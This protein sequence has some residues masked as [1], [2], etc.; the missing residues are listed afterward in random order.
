MTTPRSRPTTRPGLLARYRLALATR[1]G[2][3]HRGGLTRPGPAAL[4]E[5]PEGA[6]EQLA[7][8]TVRD[9]SD[10][11]QAGLASLRGSQWHRTQAAMIISDFPGRP[12]EIEGRTVPR[13]PMRIA[14]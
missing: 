11:E 6:A 14:T 2:P 9:Q 4:A 10:A 5:V 8:Q 7:L 3:D 12:V 1:G 13:S